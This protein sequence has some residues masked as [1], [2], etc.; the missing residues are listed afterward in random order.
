M[1]LATPHY[2]GDTLF[3]NEAKIGDVG[4]IMDIEWDT[5]DNK[6]EARVLWKKKRTVSRVNQECL[7]LTY[8]PVTEKELKQV[9]KILGVK[10]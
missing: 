3:T 2:C 9:Y 6:W 7:K 8:P 5:W 4:E 1:Y 10:P